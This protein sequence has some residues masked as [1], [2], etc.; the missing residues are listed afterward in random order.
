MTSVSMPLLGFDVWPAPYLVWS[1]SWSLAYSALACSSIELLVGAL[2]EIEKIFVGSLDPDDTAPRRE[3]ARQLQ[4]RH[5][6]DRILE[7]DAAVIEN[8]L[9]LG[10]TFHGL[11]RR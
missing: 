9:E 7:H 2:P 6:I 1:R 3:R 8:L 5:G 11:T 10:R 4:A